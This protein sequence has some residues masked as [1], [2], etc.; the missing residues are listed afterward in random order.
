MVGLV[1]FACNT[2]KKQQKVNDRKLVEKLSEKKGYLNALDLKRLKQDFSL[3]LLDQYDLSGFD[4]QDTLA[5]FVR[6]GEYVWIASCYLDED[7]EASNPFFCLKKET[8]KHFKVI[9]HGKIPSLA[10]ECSYELN[11]LLIPVD[12]YILVSQKSSGSAFCD[13]S[14]LIFHRDGKEIYH[15]ER[16]QI[17]TR[18]C[19]DE[20]KAICFERD[21]NFE[22]DQSKHLLVSVRERG[23]NWQ[24]EREISGRSFTLRFALE[25]NR[26][27]FSDTV[28]H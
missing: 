11:K 9:R 15:D 10:G 4:E 24:T 21:F 8:A 25:N 1:L 23:M 6:S 7:D 27:R 5:Y 22:W 26:L 2:P 17:I 28:F 19:P 14:P 12:R 3:N 16:F 20:T 18:N 13:E